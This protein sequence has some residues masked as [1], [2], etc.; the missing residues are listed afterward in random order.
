[1]RLENSVMMYLLWIFSIFEPAYIVYKIVDVS[2]LAGIVFKTSLNH[3]T[4][5]R[6]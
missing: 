4:Q 1:M 6:W 5:E 2:Q 3:M